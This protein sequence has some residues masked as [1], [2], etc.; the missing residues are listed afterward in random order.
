MHILSSHAQV[1]APAAP[2]DFQQNIVRAGKVREVASV[3]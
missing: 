3:A 2:E 1:G